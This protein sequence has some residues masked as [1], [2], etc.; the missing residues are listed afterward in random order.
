MQ[1]GGATLHAYP[2]TD[3]RRIA[4]ERFTTFR[5]SGVHPARGR[6]FRRTMRPECH[7]HRGCVERRVWKR[8]GGDPAIIGSELKMSSTSFTV[9]GVKLPGFGFSA[10][11]SG[12]PDMYIPLYTNLAAE[13]PQAHDFGFDPARAGIA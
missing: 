9:T 7:I 3:A 5:S 13:N 6:G 1:L 8:L 2:N 10:H 12:K 11:S 4:F